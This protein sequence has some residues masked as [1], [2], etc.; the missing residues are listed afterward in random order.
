M[1][2]NFSYCASLSLS[3]PNR[4]GAIT[5]V[6]NLMLL[7]SNRSSICLKYH[8]SITSVW[9]IALKQR[10]QFTAYTG[11]KHYESARISIFIC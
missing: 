9:L 10:T 11:N 1:V 7:C 4:S 6:M 3:T 2:W 8:D 5:L